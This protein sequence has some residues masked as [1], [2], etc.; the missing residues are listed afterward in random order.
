MAGLNVT[1]IQ[2]VN[3]AGAAIKKYNEE[4][5][6]A[7]N[8]SPDLHHIL[9]KGN[10]SVV[11]P[12]S[13]KQRSH[14]KRIQEAQEKLEQNAAKTKRTAESSGKLKH[15]KS[16]LSKLA[17]AR[18][19]LEIEKSASESALNKVVE[20]KK[21]N[22]SAMKNISTLY[23]PYD[24][25]TG[26]IR[27][28]EQLQPMLQAQ[29]AEVK[30]VGEELLLS[31]KALNRIDTAASYLT[32]MLTT[33]R[34]YFNTVEGM[35]QSQS[36]PLEVEK[37]LEEK[38]VPIAYLK[39]ASGKEDVAKERHAIMGA[40]NQLEEKLKAEKAWNSKSIEEQNELENFAKKCAQVFQRSSSC[41]EGRNSHLTLWHHGVGYLSP[42]KLS[43]ITVVHNYFIKRPDGTTAAERFF[44]QKPKDLFRYLL[45]VM[46]LPSR[47]R[48]MHL[49]EKD[50]L[51]LA[52]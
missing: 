50:K 47:S 33:M 35:I 30:S 38:L 13:S 11:G 26:A 9:T 48:K 23:H 7:A 42:R 28:V 21:R 37:I 39:I 24:L 8:E 46:P 31:R 36:L 14:E 1:V 27:T 10:Q 49:K 6:A 3:D 32:P 5:H 34:F 44:G 22:S 16:K 25:S 2:N 12:L 29:F 19:Q 51:A 4:Y 40:A 43:A 45:E 52:P 17:S 15:K 41:V 18:H 20:L